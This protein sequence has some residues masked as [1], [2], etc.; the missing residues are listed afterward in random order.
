MCTASDI[1]PDALDVTGGWRTLTGADAPAIRSATL[2]L[3]GGRLP[4]LAIGSSVD[5]NFTSA[6]GSHGQ[7]MPPDP[8]PSSE[9]HARRRV[10]AGLGTAIA[11][12][13]AGCSGR[14]PGSDQAH[15]DAEQT[16][17]DDRIVWRYPPR[18]GDREG[19][20][21]AAVSVARI[22]S[23]EN[24][25]PLARLEF[26]STIGRIAAS[27]PY[28]GYHPEWF[29]FSVRPPARYE[30]PLQYRMRV[31]PPGQWEGFGAYYDV[32][33]G[34][35]EATVELRRV[36][37]QGTIIIPAVFD[38]GVNP[39]PDALHCSFTV[40]A[41]RPGLFGKTVRVSDSGTLELPS[42]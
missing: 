39:L 9:R 38:T 17:E 2:T 21:Y 15:L 3:P 20:G 40:Q 18:E 14:L 22:V 35:R 31:E 24:Q 23:R 26:N 1:P 8:S 12:S 37:T 30:A 6:P 29:R 42:E 41:S 28:R 33:R 27:D 34:V 10:L 32:T 5:K 4:G 7:P 16:V 25:S 11:G 13:I 36:E 19:I